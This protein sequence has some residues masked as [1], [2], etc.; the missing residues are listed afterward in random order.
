MQPGAVVLCDDTCDGILEGLRETGELLDARFN[1]LLAPLIDLLLLVDDVLRAN[2]LLDC[3]LGDLLHLLRVEVLI[4]IE[5]VHDC[6]NRL[7]ILFN[8][9]IIVTWLIIISKLTLIIYNF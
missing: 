5:V 1:D 9:N 2:H 8:L 7:F 4:I 6:E 3:L